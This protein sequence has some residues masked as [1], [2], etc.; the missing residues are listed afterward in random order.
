MYA[1]VKQDIIG[2]VIEVHTRSNQTDANALALEIIGE[3]QPGFESPSEILETLQDHGVY[4]T[5]HGDIT[6][7]ETTTNG[8]L[9]AAI[10]K[11]EYR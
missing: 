2:S 7:I 11:S 8:G 3:L 1:I 5:N 9:T 10:D 4:I 6:V